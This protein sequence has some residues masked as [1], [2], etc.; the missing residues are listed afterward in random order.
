MSEKFYV[1]SKEGCGYCQ[2]LTQF[3][4]NKGVDY[5]LLNLY[6]DF[7]VEDFLNKF[8]QGSTFPQVN[9][10]NL[11][12]GGMRETVKYMISEHLV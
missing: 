10:K 9:Y 12:L 7:T 3:M 1:Y 11:N 8:G 2:R 5:E 4:S 6:D